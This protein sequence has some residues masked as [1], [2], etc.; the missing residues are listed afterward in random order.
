MKLGRILEEFYTDKYAKETGRGLL[1]PENKQHPVIPQ[2]RVNVDRLILA[3]DRPA[4]GVL[5]SKAVGRAMFYQIKR[6]GMP[7]DYV[8]Q[9]QHGMLV[10]DKSWGAFLVGNRDNGAIMHWDVERDNAI[11]DAIYEEVPKFWATVEN[12]PMPDALEPDDKRC[13]DCSWRTTC[14]GNSLSAPEAGSEYV[15]DESLAP[16]VLEFVERRALVKEAD[17]LL[18]ETKAELQFRLGD[19]GMVTA[20]GA[21]I[22]FYKIKK[23]AYSV[24]ESEYRSLRIYERKEKG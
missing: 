4:R 24:P 11:C 12:G 21:K 6:N 8:L 19:R 20:A 5:E 17:A 7:E 23:K 22:Q 3:G 2:I 9:L 16:L 18:E 13:Q 1:A 10:H 14:H 15:Q